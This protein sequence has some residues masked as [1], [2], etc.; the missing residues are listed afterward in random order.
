MAITTNHV[1][2]PSGKLILFNLCLNNVVSERIAAR[3]WPLG[4]LT[5]EVVREAQK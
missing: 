3:M 2:F 4:D 1:N 5:D